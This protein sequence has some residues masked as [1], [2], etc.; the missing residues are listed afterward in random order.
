MTSQIKFKKGTYKFH[1]NPNFNYQLNRTYAWS[2]G[3]LEELKTVA[4][5][6]TDAASWKRNY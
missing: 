2:N 3:D 1:T 5:K 4:A 6:I